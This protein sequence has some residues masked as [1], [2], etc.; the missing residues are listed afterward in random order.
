MKQNCVFFLGLTLLQLAQ[1][2]KALL[3][4]TT[5]TG[6]LLPPLKTSI[7]PGTLVRVES[8]MSASSSSSSSSIRRFSEART[9]AP[10]GT[11]LFEVPTRKTSELISYTVTAIAGD[12]LLATQLVHIDGNHETN[13]VIKLDL[14]VDRVHV[15]PAFRAL[16]ASRNINIGFDFFDFFDL[17]KDFDFDF[18]FDLE[19][20]PLVLCALILVLLMA[21]T[22]KTSRRTSTPDDSILNDN[23]DVEKQQP[24]KKK[25]KVS[26]QLQQ[27]KLQKHQP[28]SQPQPQPQPQSQPNN[29]NPL[30]RTHIVVV[31]R[32]N[33]K[34]SSR[35]MLS[36]DGLKAEII[37]LFRL[38][39]DMVA[40]SPHAI[41]HAVSF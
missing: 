31:R 38:N 33:T 18:D 24:G 26:Q 22:M 27:R 6:P 25:K 28:Q 13:S 37:R 20:V 5:K 36:R 9:S 1:A 19:C 16:L 4:I 14:V 30:S 32:N 39:N 3:I 41:T 35:K 23:D 21:K 17:D 29:S 15:L 7:R 11:V 40:D 10:D 34:K 12:A 2:K 8:V